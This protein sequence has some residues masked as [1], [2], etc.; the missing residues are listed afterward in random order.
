MTGM[1][2]S[3]LVTVGV[4]QVRKDIKISEAIDI[5]LDIPVQITTETLP[6]CEIYDR[7]IAENIVATIP[8]PP[9]DRSPFDG[10]AFC[11]VDTEGASAEHPVTLQVNQEIPAGHAPKREVT[12]G[13]AAKILTGA[14]IPPGADAVVKFEDT[15]FTGEE[16]T[17]FASSC[18]GSN[19]IR[20]GEDVSA[21]TLLAPKGIAATPALMGLLAAQGM[22]FV[23]V[24]R[25]PVI[26]VISTGS[27]LSEFGQPLLPGMIYDSNI[28]ALRGFIQR[29]N[30][31]F[32]DGGVVKDN[33]DEIASRIYDELVRSDMVIT[34]GG[35]SVGDYDC[36]LKAG[37]KSDGEILFWKVRMRP[38]GAILAYTLG[39]KLVFALSGNPGAAML[40]ISR[41]GLT[42]IRKLCGYSQTIPESC[43]VRLTKNMGK[44]S[45][46]MRLLRG[47]LEINNGEASFVENENQGGGDISSFL[48]CDL[49]AEVPEGSPPLPAGTLVKAYRI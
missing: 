5:L 29:H 8:F 38:G 25:R 10:Y 15:I 49:L 35:A 46:K 48:R 43:M 26:S 39:G 13:L 3:T 4:V 47:Y 23:K 17:L 7:V 24:F 33:E 40:G 34:T 45:P 16:V 28:Y 19:I 42:Y 22:R 14:P 12:S 18:S 30:A 41:I 27:E 32:R 2:L 44:S 36:A 11:A 6:I 37:E 20:A 31:D 21:G 9:F 1:V